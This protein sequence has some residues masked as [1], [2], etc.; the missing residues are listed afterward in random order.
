VFRSLLK[1]PPP[2][3]S[4]AH[5]SL[6]DVQSFR[7][8]CRAHYLNLTHSGK[9]LTEA[10]IEEY[11]GTYRG[12]EEEKRDVCEVVRKHNGDVSLLLSQVVGSRDDDVPRLLLVVEELFSDKELPARMK[13]V[14]QSLARS[15]I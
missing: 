8:H 2:S 1:N 3:S 15:S 13:K 11:L 12:S 10:D 7:L 4:I 5:S 6:T 14:S 9:P